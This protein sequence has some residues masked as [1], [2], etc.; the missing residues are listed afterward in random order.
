MKKINYFFKKITTALLLILIT[1]FYCNE[2]SAQINEWTIMVYMAADNDLEINGISDF[3]EMEAIGSTDD[4]DVLVQFDRTSGYDKSNGDWTDTKRFRVEKDDNNTTISTL[5]IMELGEVNMGDTASLTDFIDWATENYPA[6]HYALVLWNHGGGWRKEEGVD[7]QHYKDVCFDETDFDNLSNSEVTKAIRRSKAKIDIIAYDACLMGMMEVAYQVKDDAKIMVASED[8]IPLDGFDY[9]S[10]LKHLTDS[11]SI[12]PDSLSKVIVNTFLNFSGY[13]FESVALSAIDLSKMNDLTQKMDTMVAAIIKDDTLWDQIYT[14]TTF[15]THFL[16]EPHIDIVDLSKKIYNATDN[17]KIKTAIDSFINTFANA[18]IANKWKGSYSDLYGLSIYL[19]NPSNY[20]ETYIA[21]DNENTFPDSTLWDEFIA[22]YLKKTNTFL[23]PNNIPASAYA[24]YGNTDTIASKIIDSSDIDYFRFFHIKKYPESISIVAR[25][26]CMMKLIYVKDTLITV[27]DTV[28][29]NDV[30]AQFILS[31]QHETGYYYVA[32]SSRE[33]KL[34]NYT[35]KLDENHMPFYSDEE[36][37]MV[38]EDG[39]PQTSFATEEKNEGIGMFI[40]ES[41]FLKGI[42]YYITDLNVNPDNDNPASF[43]FVSKNPFRN[44]ILTPEKLGWNYLDLRKY[45]IWISNDIVGFEWTD[46]KNKP[47]IGCDSTYA[48][49]CLYK[50]SGS[51]KQS[52]DSLTYFLRPV[53]SLQEP[54]VDTCFCETFTELKSLS[55]SFNDKSGTSF[56]GNESNCKWLIQPDRASSIT[57][58]FNEFVTEYGYDSVCV[59]DGVDSLAPLLAILTGYIEKDTSITSTE[60]AMFIQFLTDEN[61]SSWG[62]SATYNSRIILSDENTETYTH[63]AYPNP[64]NGKIKLDLNTET[65]K[66][67]TIKVVNISGTTVFFNE[68]VGDETINIDISNNPTG[69]YFIE[70]YKKSDVDRISYILQ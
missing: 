15:M 39:E 18:T 47:A 59:Y 36:L 24:F 61:Y 68:F 21:I 23:E 25:E 32:V 30:P 43:S 6:K 11:P 29:S 46:N 1:I 8:G 17:E 4:V 42:W 56:Y 10:L 16:D 63:N 49:G 64:G 58:T 20:D 38:Y 60:G 13:E 33:K 2:T 35:I 7:N 19:P 45:D 51:W 28:Y 55:G 22:A 44:V 67:F 34:V 9:K 27:L 14:F 26:K 41:G 31:T 54:S 40:N 3:N 53:L 62:W 66:K 48:D 12:E 70:I 65:Q 50:Y 37:I 57:I 5:P 69:I 52:T